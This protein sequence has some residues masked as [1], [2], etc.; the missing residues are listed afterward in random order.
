M[1]RLTAEVRP[2]LILACAIQGVGAVAGIVPFVAVVELAGLLLGDGPADQ[3]IRWAWIAGGALAV[4]L[5]CLI[6]SGA[7]S[8]RA[9][10]DLQLSIRRQIAAHLSRVPLSWFS[11]RN[12]G[13]LKKTLLDDVAALHDVVGHAYTATVSA[14]VL[15]VAALAYL[16]WR[17]LVLVPASLFPVVVGMALY[18]MQFRG[19]GE[20][21]QAY[22]TALAQIGAAAVEYVQGIAVVKTFSGTGRAFSRFTRRA[23]AFL[24]MFWNWISGLLSYAAAADI[25]L[26]P[27]TAVLIASGL[28]LSMAEAGWITTVDALALIVLAPALTAPFLALSFAQHGVM[29][30]RK[31]ADRI[32]EVLDA[33]V[34]TRPDAPRV[35]TGNRI[36]FESVHAAYDDDRKVLSEI[37]LALEPGTTTALIGP[38]GSG[39][40]TLAKLL[41]R[42]MDPVAGQITLGGVPLPEI[43]PE[44]LYARVGYVFQDVRLLRASVRDNIALGAREA[45]LDTVMGAART[46]CI[47]DRITALPRGYDTVIGEDVT[48]SGGE[49]QRVTIARAL[50]ADP[51]VLVLDEALAFADADTSQA[52]R[53]ALAAWSG[54]RTL[55][56]VA[57]DLATVRHA[58]QICALDEGRIVE[59]GSHDALIRQGGLYA[60]LWRAGE[61]AA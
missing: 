16:A 18:A 38:S 56:I 14:I 15:P 55:L 51:P 37:D 47:H 40:S 30:A 36:V 10:A 57:H 13:A 39:K 26:S 2:T 46:A 42:F 4:R 12:A 6:A 50:L 49:A 61:R 53:N 29:Q 1:R 33:P 23:E 20:K 27:L 54:R 7:L 48:L 28:G 32:V 58:D 21:M 3:A 35:P 19:Y 43:A 34:L 44:T 22:E 52:L 24:E 17:D 45:D 41:P 5:F 9:D 31:A 59:R 60:R 25:V 11:R 8:H